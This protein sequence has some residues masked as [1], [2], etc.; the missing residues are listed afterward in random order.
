MNAPIG[1]Y[2]LTGY[3]VDCLRAEIRLLAKRPGEGEPKA[4]EVLFRGVEAYRFE[5]DN[6]GTLLGGI[7]EMPLMPF[8]E[9][10][11]EQFSEGW[12]QSGWPHFWHGSVLEAVS[13]LQE[14]SVHVFE[15]TSAIGM[16]G[17][18]LAREFSAQP[19]RDEVP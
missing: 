5:Y 6:F 9:R 8:I 11:A 16:H 1:D 2:L 10:H 12:H 15:L 17:W 18:I 19:I 13:Y 7:V 4:T 3:F 14:A